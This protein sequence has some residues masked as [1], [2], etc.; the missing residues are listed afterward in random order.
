MSRHSR[1]RYVGEQIGKGRTLADVLAGMTMVAEGVKTCKAAKR[2]AGKLLVEMPICHQVYKVLFNG[3][4]PK[5]AMQ[6]LMTRKVKSE[7]WY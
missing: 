7:I 4:D 5:Q 3:K 6:D 2:L 1:N